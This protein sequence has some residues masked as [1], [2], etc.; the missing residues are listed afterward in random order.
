M[1]RFFSELPAFGRS[2]VISEWLS[3]LFAACQPT[4]RALVTTSIAL[5]VSSCANLD[6][7]LPEDIVAERS[8]KRVQL[9]MEGDIDDSYQFTTPGYRSI[10]TA[11]RYGIRWAGV[12]MWN[13]VAVKSVSCKSSEAPTYC[14]VVL[15]VN[16]Q[17]FRADEQS[18]LLFEDWVY[19]DGDWYFRQKIL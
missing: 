5:A 18:T 16:F 7:P 12:G 15:L 11:K 4:S 14:E 6:A 13:S 3:K 2:V 1:C 17:T 8:L 10:E 9:L 19:I